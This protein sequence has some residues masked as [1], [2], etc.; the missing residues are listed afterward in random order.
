[1]LPKTKQE[2]VLK[3]ENPIKYRKKRAIETF[4]AATEKGKYNYWLTQEDIADI[5]RIEFNFFKNPSTRSNLFKFEISGSIAQLTSQII[6]FQS[7]A[8]LPGSRI[9]LIV[10]LSN[11]HWVTL[12]LSRHYSGYDGFYIDS[13][14]SLLPNEY[15]TLLRRFN[16]VINDFSLNF[17]QQ[18]DDYNCG[19]WALENAADLNKM[20]NDMQPT[21]WLNY[22]LKRPRNHYY[23]NTIRR[24]LVEKLQLDTA[25]RERLQSYGNLQ[26]KSELSEILESEQTGSAPKRIKVQGLEKESM[27]M[28]LEIFVESFIS[29]SNQKLAAY[30]LI[31]RGEKLSLNALKQEIKTGATGALF[32]FIVSRGLI[33]TISSMVTSLRTV[34]HGYYI[35]KKKAQKITRFFSNVNLVDMSNN[36]AEAAVE[37]FKSYEAQFMHVTDKAGDK[38]AIQKLAEDAVIRFMNYISKQADID[39]LSVEYI[40]K[41]IIFGNSD[42]YFDLKLNKFRL[43]ISGNAIKDEYANTIY[44]SDL[45]ENVGLAIFTVDSTKFYKKIKLAE[46]D[47]YGYRDVLSWEKTLSNTLIEDYTSKYEQI[48]SYHTST[49]LK[50]DV[51]SYRHLLHSIAAGIKAQTILDKIKNR[52]QDTSIRK[53][54][55]K[56]TILFN[57]RA[58]VENFIGR[59]APLH[60]LHRTL[61]SAKTTSIVSA[62]TAMSL[63]S[64]TELMPGP[65]ASVSGLGGIGKT[66]LALRY[67]Q[68][69]AADYDNNV[70]WI[71]SETKVAMSQ[72]F[73]KLADKLKIEKK[74]EYGE[75]N[76]LESLVE[77]IYEYFS[78]RKSLFIFDNVE[79]Y[80]E[81]EMFLPKLMLGNKPHL[82]ITS[83]YRNWKNA[84]P[85]ISLDVFTEK[86]ALA[87]VKQGLSLVND[88]QDNKINELNHLLHGLPLALQQA[89]AYI[90]MQRNININ[91]NI[92][93][94]IEIFKEKSREVLDFNFRIYNNDPYLKTAYTTWK[95]TLDL[96]KKEGLVGET[97]LEVLNIMSFICPENIY[98]DMLIIMYHPTRLSMAMELLESYSMLN[99]G[100][101]PSEYVMHRLVQK[102]VN[103][104]LQTNAK[105]FKEVAVKTEISV[106]YFSKNMDTRYHYLYFLFNVLEHP[107]LQNYLKY[108]SSFKRISTILMVDDM[109]MWTSFFDMVYN[110]FNKLR[111]VEFL[112]EAFLNYRRQVAPFY[113]LT[114][115]A[116][117]EKNLVKGVLTRDDVKTIIDN[118]DL[119]G[120]RTRI[121]LSKIPEKREIQLYIAS[122]IQRFKDEIF[123]EKSVTCLSDR[124]K[125]S[126]QVSCLQKKQL[127]KEEK[128]KKTIKHL[129]NV[130]HIAGFASTSL[131]TKDIIAAF[132]RGDFSTC[133]L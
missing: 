103:L 98:M 71:N 109:K 65:S 75:Y 106:M 17:V 27:E 37:I 94:Y 41:G 87:L 47:H 86:E 9:T 125:R 6:E 66:Q 80:E 104:H 100:I 63:D 99:A 7:S 107:E 4:E 74:D 115:L 34:S 24:E 67:A 113:V 61:S 130:R 83:R 81:I 62:M 121:K 23:F 57:L 102:V 97:A 10:N 36:L 68:L 116:Y 85:V 132:I 108:K 95:V 101:T 32:G 43:S 46:I 25:R 1:M 21:D 69:H 58:P 45:Y 123:L 64:R 18:T 31:A 76:K 84:A 93:K 122:S 128:Q 12:V 15:Y 52:L 79:N 35:S 30:Q 13:Q 112:T 110:R 11:L 78:D 38:I 59:T 60:E 22:Q 44:T 120:V 8:Q 77:E 124:K 91:F 28:R 48:T 119:L 82:L 55:E 126:M 51:Q 133:I 114:M 89:V 40:T 39:Y 129:K 131:F 88:A 56:K 50:Q 42:K 29:Y 117:L 127:L 92:E 33:G 16:V 96:I 90:K 73:F 14:G 118:E 54:Q 5:A 2:H 19:L 3:T 20:L 70:L 26:A 49:G 53:S 72:S 111:Y 105:Q